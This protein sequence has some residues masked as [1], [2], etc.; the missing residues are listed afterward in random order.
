MLEPSISMPPVTEKADHIPRPLLI[1]G[2]SWNS[3]FLTLST[4]IT[5]EPSPSLDHRV[6]GCICLLSAF[7]L[8][9]ELCPVRTSKMLDQMVDGTK[10]LSHTLWKSGAPGRD[11][12]I[13]R[14]E[15]LTAV[16]C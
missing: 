6:N 3:S 9:A 2:L 8:L 7:L 16:S 15:P 12:Y 13:D 11:C 1:W 4:R 5:C 14:S 10:S